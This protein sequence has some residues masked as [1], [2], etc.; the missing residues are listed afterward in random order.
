M[1]EQPVTLDVHQPIADGLR[2]MAERGF[3][4]I[5]LVDGSAQPTAVVSFRDIADYLETTFM[6]LA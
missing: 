2:M 5:P 4:H 1:T 6:S 3:S